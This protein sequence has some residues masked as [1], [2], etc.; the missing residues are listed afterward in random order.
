MSSE[1]AAKDSLWISNGIL[2]SPP[3]H[4]HPLSA[5]GYSTH[6]LIDISSSITHSAFGLKLLQLICLFVCIYV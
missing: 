4:T 5:M 2:T 3:T 1:I 6:S